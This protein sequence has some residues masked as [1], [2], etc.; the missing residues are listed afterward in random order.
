MPPAFPFSAGMSKVNYKLKS[1]PVNKY[2]TPKQCFMMEKWARSPYSSKSSCQFDWQLQKRNPWNCMASGMSVWNSFCW[3]WVETLVE[4][5]MVWK[6]YFAMFIELGQWRAGKSRKIPFISQRLAFRTGYQSGRSWRI[7]FRAV[8]CG[9]DHTRGTKWEH[10]LHIDNP[11]RNLNH[12]RFRHKI[13]DKGLMRVIVRKN[14]SL[15]EYM[16]EIESVGF[17]V[18][19]TGNHIRKTW[20][21]VLCWTKIS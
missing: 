2:M 16:I 19:N 20:C 6:T 1:C 3:T 18:S 14:V 7:I 13:M 12:R 11:V 17:S 4:P 8:D 9:D 21:S 15:W 10:V 5:R